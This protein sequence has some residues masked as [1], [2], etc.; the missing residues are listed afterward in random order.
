MSKKNNI[1]QDKPTVSVRID[2]KY[3][4]RARRVLDSNGF[5]TDTL[6]EIVRNCVLVVIKAMGIDGDLEDPITQAEENLITAYMMGGGNKRIIEERLNQLNEELLQEMKGI[7]HT[8][9]GIMGQG[10]RLDMI[11]ELA[12][13]VRARHREEQEAMRRAELAMDEGVGGPI[14]VDLSDEDDGQSTVIDPQD[15]PVVRLLLGDVDDE[16]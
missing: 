12:K 16:D 4:A 10:E 1:D 7:M 9:S 2:K 5:A 3:L 11:K 8:D 13:E 14:I 15:D 6:A